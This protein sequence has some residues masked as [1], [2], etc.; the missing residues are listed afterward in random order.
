[1]QTEV[2][3]ADV[4]CVG[5]GIAG[6]MAAIRAAELGAKVVVVEKANAWRSG[7][8]AVGNDHFCCYIPEIHG[9]DVEVILKEASLTQLRPRIENRPRARVWWGKTFDIIKLWED[10]GIPMKYHGEYEFAGH[11]FPGRPFGPYI[12]YSGQMQKRVLTQQTL[13]RGV[14]IINRVMVM[15]LLGNKERVTGAIGVGT[16]EDKLWLFSAKSVFLGTGSLT[17]LYQGPTPAWMSNNSRPFTTSGDG[18]AMAYRLGA[19]LVNMEMLS[20]HAG[21]K[22][23]ARDGQ[24]TWVG[25]LRDPRGNPVGPFLKRPNRMYSDM[26]TEVN[27]DLFSEYARSGK[28]PVYMDCRGI[29]DEDLDYM[30]HWLRNEGNEALINHLKEEGVDLTKNPVEFQTFESMCAGGIKTGL[31]GE[32]SVKGLY[33][34]GDENIGGISAAATLGWIAGD[35]AAKYVEKVKIPSL[36]KEKSKIK[37]RKEYLEEIRLHRAGPDWREVNIALQQTMNDYA[38]TLRSQNVLDAGLAH[39]R[40]LKEKARKTIIA[41]N[42]HELMRALETLNLLDLGELVFLTAAERKESRNLHV[43]ADYPYTNPLLDRFIAVEK[44]GNK[45]VVEWIEKGY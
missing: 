11:R 9:P 18:R 6:L 29:T 2:V 20:R 26:I 42:Q 13:S 34:A 21:P 41:R 32:S 16:R 33:A 17:R 19:V 43:R 24:G 14:K 30:M 23:F 44:V 31:K 37:E 5:G 27:K 28:G 38:G 36:E 22:Y 8:G 1:M 45:P 25:V 10:W 15:D 35:E 39:L 12:K 40:R 7:A 3:E 4:L